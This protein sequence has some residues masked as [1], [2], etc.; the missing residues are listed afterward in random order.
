MGKKIAILMSTYNGEKYLDEQLRSIER[1]TVSEDISLYIRDDGSS[2]NTIS[3]IKRWMDKMEIKLFAGENLGPAMSF[4]SLLCN[5]EITADY[6]LFCDQDDIWDKDKVEKSVALLSTDCV[7]SVCNSRYID[8]NGIVV[9]ELRLNRVPKVT[10][11]SLF[12]SG[13]A[14]G[15]AMAFTDSLRRY[16]V[17]QDLKCIPMHDIVLMLYACILGEIRWREEPLMSYRL[18]DNN[19][20]AKAR[21]SP[22]RKIVTALS[23]WNNSKRMSM[24]TVAEEMLRSREL[25]NKEQLTFLKNMSRYKG[26]LPA[27]IAIIRNKNCTSI[28]PNATRSFRAR[29][30]LNLL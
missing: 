26:S 13:V 8:K 29:M 22:V 20:V 14:Q 1:Q 6:Y 27:K 10:L 7:L 15:C 18:H 2:D 16:L 12:V 21:K 30:L 11:E 5:K 17:S 23:N 28:W 9:Q 25:L 19:V 24:A 4:W 3:I